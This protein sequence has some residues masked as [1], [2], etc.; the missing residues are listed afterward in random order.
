MM[1][2]LQLGLAWGP[3]EA[4]AWTDRGDVTGHANGLALGLH[5]AVSEHVSLVELEAAAC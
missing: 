5:Q 1:G 3:V 2:V 4:S